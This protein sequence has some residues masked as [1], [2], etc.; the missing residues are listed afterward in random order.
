MDRQ[1]KRP[2]MC[3]RIADYTAML[4]RRQS[5]SV[6][7]TSPARR[8]SGSCPVLARRLSGAK[9]D[10]RRNG[11]VL[12]GKMFNPSRACFS[13]FSDYKMATGW[14]TILYCL[15]KKR[16]HRRR[17]YWIHRINLQRETYGEF[18]HLVDEVLIDEE[19]CLSYI[20][21]R[22]CTFH[23]LLDLIAPYITKRET[24]FRK[25]IPAKQRLVIT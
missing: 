13:V 11:D 10:Y 5:E 21:M 19:N 8:Q 7:G 9:T 3:Y 12:G 24:N 2:N 15:K 17:R 22:P 23:S 16:Y 1:Q 14:L 6:A 18:Y 25:P 4:E 20:R